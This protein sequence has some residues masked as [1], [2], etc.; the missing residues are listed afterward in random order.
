[1]C[2]SGLVKLLLSIL[3]AIGIVELCI[4]IDGARDHIEVELLGLARAVIHEELKALR[5]GIGQPL[6]NGEA[7]ALGLGNLLALVVEEQFID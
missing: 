2:Q 5:V 7:V 3:L 1:M 6:I 4:L